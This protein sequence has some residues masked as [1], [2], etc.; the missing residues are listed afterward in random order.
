MDGAAAIITDAFT[1]I[2]ELFHKALPDMSP[3]E[4]NGGPKPPIGWLTWRAARVQDSQVT[5]LAGQEQAWTS[6]GWHARFEMKPELHDYGRAYSHTPEQVEAFRTPDAQ[7]LLDYLDT[8]HQR[9][10]TYLAGLSLQDLEQT[11]DEPRF[12]PL[13]TVGVRL[14]SI[15]TDNLQHAGQVHYLRG[16]M[17]TGGWFPNMAS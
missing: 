13:P 7:T 16:F 9:T 1:R 3:E 2:N 17:R 4:L 10:T 15:I 6:L 8:V 5:P 12:T 14:V 11:L